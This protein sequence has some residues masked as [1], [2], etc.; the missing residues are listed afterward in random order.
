ML[1]IFFTY[2]FSACIKK[3]VVKDSV[4]TQGRMDE[5]YY[6]AE[7]WFT[8][9][10]IKVKVKSFMTDSSLIT[11]HLAQSLIPGIHQADFQQSFKTYCAGKEDL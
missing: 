7:S 11:L 5:G 2:V 9:A 4:V 10:V 1:I 3:P 6:S 8:A